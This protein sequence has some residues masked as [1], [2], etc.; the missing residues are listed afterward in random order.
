MSNKI[1]IIDEFEPTL[2]KMLRESH[3]PFEYAP[4]LNREGIL[5]IIPEYSGLIVRSKTQIDKEVIDKG[6]NLLFIAR[7]G[8]GMDNIDEAYANK[9]EITCLNTPEGN[10]NAVAEHTLGLILS[11][12]CNI[13][14]GNKEINENIWDREGNRGL[15]LSSLKVGIIGIGNVGKQVAEKLNA[16][17]VNIFCYDKYKT[18]FKEDYI[19]VSSLE[20]I[21]KQCNAIS[22]HVPLT[23]ETRN[24]VNE[25]FINQFDNP[26]YLINTS[27]GPVVNLQDVRNSINNKKIIGVGLDVLENE[28]IMELNDLELEILNDL[29][30][31]PNTILTP[32]VA[33]WT[34]ESYIGISKVLGD[35][36][37]SMLTKSEYFAKSVL[38]NLKN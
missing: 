33:G 13:T 34:K 17:G 20:E 19:N 27:R 24:M 9:K 7:G 15:E 14:K 6:V 31:S 10:R 8:S 37:I 2:M 4:Y 28:K 26:F 21:K 23:S 32:H 3:I 36:I 5:D 12:I 29:K 18:E 16:L 1:L 22:I 11:L 25:K 35:K 30:R 38:I